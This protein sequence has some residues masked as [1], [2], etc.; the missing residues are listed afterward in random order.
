VGTNV[1]LVNL[2]A[3][4]TAARVAE[5]AGTRKRA[6]R[7]TTRR[8]HGAVVYVERT[9]ANILASQAVARVARIA[10]ARGRLLRICASSI[11]VAAVRV[12]CALVV[13][14]AGDAVAGPADVAAA[15][16]RTVCVQ[17]SG[18]YIAVV[19]VACTLVD[20]VA[21]REANAASARERAGCVGAR[22]FPATRAVTKGAP[23]RFGARNPAA[24]VASKTRAGERAAR[25]G[26]RGLEVA[27]VRVERALVDR[28]VAHAD[29]RPADVASARGRPN[30]RT[31]GLFRT[32]GR[33]VEFVHVAARVH[34]VTRACE[35]ALGV[36]ALGLA[37][38]V[39]RIQCALVDRGAAHEAA[40]VPGVARA[41][42]RR[43]KRRD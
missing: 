30:L 36:G 35:R 22:R 19:Q 42:G 13:V 33:H 43:R 21:A 5:I 17:A 37:S 11:D 32:R 3:R 9:L 14:G 28:R 10:R 29:A 39:V 41:R 27:V 4:G 40:R 2:G 15:H 12:E 16:E 6:H 7:V 25:V 34:G 8:R 24:G 23:V 20:I 1:A 31:R 26:A 38:A 18:M